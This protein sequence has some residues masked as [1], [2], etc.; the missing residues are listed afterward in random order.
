MWKAL[1]VAVQLPISS[2]NYQKWSGYSL[3]SLDGS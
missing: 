2:K 1:S 3:T